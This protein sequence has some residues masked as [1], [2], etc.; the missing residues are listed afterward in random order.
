MLRIHIKVM[1]IMMMRSGWVV[2]LQLNCIS[3]V[4]DAND[5]FKLH[6]NDTVCIFIMKLQVVVS[7]FWLLSIS[8]QIIVHEFMTPYNQHAHTILSAMYLVFTLFTIQY[9]GIR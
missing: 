8:M 3:V 4:S 2:L 7:S 6:V 9:F 5:N 1:A